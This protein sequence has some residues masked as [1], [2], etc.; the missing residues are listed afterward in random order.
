MQYLDNITFLETENEQL[1]AYLK[2]TG[3]NAV[4]VVVNLDPFATREGVCLLPVSTGLPPAYRV[5]DL[6]DDADWTWHIGRNY[7]RL[8]PGKSHVLR[9]VR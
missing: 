1:F 5:H 9:I 8:A 4:I 7:V 6:L 3:G 2:R